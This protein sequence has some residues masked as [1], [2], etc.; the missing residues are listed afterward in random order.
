MYKACLLAGL[1]GRSSLWQCRL[2]CG[3]CSE[4]SPVGELN[5]KKA[6]PSSRAQGKSPRFLI[7][8]D[9]RTNESK[10]TAVILRSFLA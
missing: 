1:V 7:Y 10:T 3:N 5:F 6:E 8:P 2:E 4:F 9:T